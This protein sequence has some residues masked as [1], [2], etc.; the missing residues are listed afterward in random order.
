MNT[1]I[2]DASITGV[3]LFDDELD[4]RADVALT[5]LEDDVALVP[6]LWHVEVRS[7]LLVA[8]R[9][10]RIRA[11]EV[12]ERLLW[13]GGLPIQTDAQP[14]LDTALSLARTHGLS[15]YD[16]V[17]LELDQR[18]QATLATLDAALG[19]AAT[20]EGLILVE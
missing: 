6:Q 7:V 4:P 2:L 19:R 14:D 16:A 18:R 12:D 15:F 3:W 17:Y 10:G 5:R 1:M 11:G 20:A 9:R 8:E 13:L